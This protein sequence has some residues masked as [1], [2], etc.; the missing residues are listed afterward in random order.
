M[1]THVQ[2]EHF[3]QTVNSEFETSKLVYLYWKYKLQFLKEKQ[4]KVNFA[5]CEYVQ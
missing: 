2:E 5:V 3:L 1:Q 4:S